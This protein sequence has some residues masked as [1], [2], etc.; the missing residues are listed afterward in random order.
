[1]PDDEKTTGIP[2]GSEETTRIPAEDSTQAPV[3]DAPAEQTTWFGQ[4]EQSGRTGVEEP[5]GQER[6]R[7]THPLQTGYL[8]I[9]LLAIG[10]ALMWLLTDQGVVEGGDGG[11]LFSVVLITAGA[12]G[13][14]ASLGKGLR[15]G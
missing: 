12:V 7:G 5:G 1:M 10:V 3:A 14:A 8:V 11:V 9:G 15:R 6:P 2:D 13:L 4:W